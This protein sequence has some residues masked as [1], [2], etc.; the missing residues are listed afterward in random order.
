MALSERARRP[1]LTIGM[2]CYDDFN[3]VYFTIQAIRTYHAEVIEQLDFL[4]VDN[5]PDGPEGQTV[6]DFL[7]SWV[8]NGRY[9]PAPQAVGTSAPRDLVFHLAAGEAILCLDC[10]VLVAPGALRRLLQF[11]EAH[12]ACRDL[13]HGPLLYDNGH[14]AATHMDPVWRCEMLGT[15][16]VDPRGETEDA[17]PFEVP[18]HGCG[19]MSCRKE[20]WL[21]FH[22][23]FR[24]FGGEEGYIHEKFRRA[25]RRVLCLPFLRWLHRFGRPG[26][27]RY[28]LM[29]ENRV[30]NYL[31]GRVELGLPY[32]DVIDHFAGTMSREQIDAILGDLGL[33]HLT[34]HRS[35][36]RPAGYPAADATPRSRA[37]RAAPARPGALRFVKETFFKAPI[38]ALAQRIATG[39]SR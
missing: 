13:L 39:G 8:P 30:R 33:P 7:L 29:R 18:M 6:R 26:G 37:R 11:Y 19:L 22:P 25:G 9:V 4:V 5:H 28:P 15:W 14:I 31:L 35:P 3:G 16:G 38:N 24:G 36:C 20:A 23:Q 34:D 1:R 12:P 27:V 17:P 10:H 2:A 32:E 21:G